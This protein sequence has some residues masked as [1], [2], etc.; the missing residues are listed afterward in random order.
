V[1]TVYEVGW[2]CVDTLGSCVFP[3]LS[4]SPLSVVLISGTVQSF[5]CCDIEF[6]FVCN[7]LGPP[8]DEV[9]LSGVGHSE[10]GVLHLEGE[11]H[12][13]VVETALCAVGRA[14]VVEVWHELSNL[15]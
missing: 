1:N 6:E 8:G 9:L 7:L 5:N 10:D 11:V 4:D 2:S 15:P 3:H 14:K 13:L 12:V